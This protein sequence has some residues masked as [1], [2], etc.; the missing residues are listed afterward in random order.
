MPFSEDMAWKEAS[1]LYKHFTYDVGK[2]IFPVD[3]NVWWYF[4]NHILL[5][6]NPYAK[7]ESFGWAKVEANFTLDAVLWE[8]RHRG[9]PRHLQGAS[10]MMLVS[11]TEEDNYFLP[12]GIIMKI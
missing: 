2:D 1:Q 4:T 3:T 10:F 11:F 12:L 5:F 9:I 6:Y 7:Q 8:R